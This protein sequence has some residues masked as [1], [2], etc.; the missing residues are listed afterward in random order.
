MKK[1]LAS[2]DAPAALG[3]YSQAIQTGGFVFASGQ[4]GL[5]SDG[6]LAEGGV[7][8]QAMQVM[9]NIKAVL[10]E[11][12]L[13]FSHVVKST[14]FLLD[15]ADFPVFNEVYGSHFAEPY[16]AR[17]TFQVAALPGGGLV[18]VEVIARVP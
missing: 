14:C 18:E 2:K 4:L 1:V 13:D 6:K 3:P 12:G 16:P 9:A 11:A 17:S 7:R 8:E 15:M 5:T 10:A